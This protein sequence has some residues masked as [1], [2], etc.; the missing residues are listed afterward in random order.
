MAAALLVNAPASGIQHAIVD[1]Q[2]GLHSSD[3]GM[4]AVRTKSQTR[5]V[6]DLAGPS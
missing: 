1:G 6:S 4:A 2:V 5:L 3:S